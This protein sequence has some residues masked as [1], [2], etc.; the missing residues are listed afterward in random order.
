MSVRCVGSC[1]GIGRPGGVGPCSQCSSYGYGVI[2]GH[3][4]KLQIFS[5]SG[6]AVEVVPELWTSVQTR[7]QL[8]CQ[9]C[10]ASH[11]TRLLSAARAPSCATRFKCHKDGYVDLD[12]LVYDLGP[13]NDFWAQLS[14][15]GYD[16]CIVSSA[17]VGRDVV[18][19]CAGSPRVVQRMFAFAIPG[20][21]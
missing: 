13:V 12:L 14:A 4:T 11:G 15:A 19:Y 17:E 7:R 21:A 3:S 6:V 16:P 18:T 10:A 1:V 9:T 5:A 8:R 20:I 2:G